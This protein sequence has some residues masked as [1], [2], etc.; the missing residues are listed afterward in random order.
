MFFQFIGP[1][2]FGQLGNLAVGVVE[3]PEIPGMTNALFH[4][5]GK[6]PV[7]R[8]TSNGEAFP[9]RPPDAVAMTFFSRPAVF[10]ALARRSSTPVMIVPTQPRTWTGGGTDRE[11]RAGRSV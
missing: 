3:V 8:V 7:G 10:S 1:T 2:A 4:A 11:P 6:H 9:F 5:R